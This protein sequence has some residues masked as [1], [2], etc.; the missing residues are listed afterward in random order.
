[1]TWFMYTTEM[2]VAVCKACRTRFTDTDAERLGREMDAHET[3]C[4]G[5]L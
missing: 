4:R 2:H 5:G 3:E 1:M